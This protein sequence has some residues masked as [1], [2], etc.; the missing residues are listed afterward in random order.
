LEFDIKGLFD[1]ID[2]A[3]LSRA[4]AKHVKC[5]WAMLYISRWLT[6]CAISPAVQGGE[7]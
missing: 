3:L 2:H 7:G 1:N 5:D 4:L 6:G